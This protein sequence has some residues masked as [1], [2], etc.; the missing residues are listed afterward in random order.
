M[1]VWEIVMVASLVAFV[2]WPSVTGQPRR[3][4]GWVPIIVALGALL[5]HIRTEDLRWQLYPIYALVVVVAVA[6]AWEII[7]PSP[8]SPEPPAGRWSQL[9]KALGGVFGLAL[10]TLPALALPDRGLRTQ[11]WRPPPDRPA[12]LVPGRRG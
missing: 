5:M 7:S 10:L 12:G 9:G 1:R 6:T 11:S 8:V 3:P 4:Y 2:L